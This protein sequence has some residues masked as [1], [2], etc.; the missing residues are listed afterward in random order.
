M[1]DNPMDEPVESGWATLICN[2]CG[3]VVH[4]PVPP[5]VTGNEFREIILGIAAQYGWTRGHDDNGALDWCASC[6]LTRK[7]ALN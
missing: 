3:A 4:A 2:G 5:G 6:T 7:A 1:T